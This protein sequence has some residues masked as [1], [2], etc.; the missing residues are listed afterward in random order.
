MTFWN[1]NIQYQSGRVGRVVSCP[2]SQFFFSVWNVS[3]K[4]E[5]NKEYSKTTDTWQHGLYYYNE[6]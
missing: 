4:K 1:S 2:I 3:L 6:L 5:K